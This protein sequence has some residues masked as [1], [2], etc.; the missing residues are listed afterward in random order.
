MNKHYL[1]GLKHSLGFI[2][3]LSIFF[4]II[5]AAGFHSANE[6][7]GGVFQGNFSIIGSMNFTSANT[8]GIIPTGALLSFNSSECPNGWS[9]STSSGGHSIKISNNTGTIIGDMTD[10]GGITASFDGITSQ[11][12]IQSSRKT[13]AANGYIGKDWGAQGAY[14]ITRVDLYPSND[15]GFTDAANIELLAIYTNSA[16]PSNPQ[17][18][19]QIWSIGP[20]IADQTT[21]YS[22]TGISTD[23]RYVW[24]VI[25]GS[26]NSNLYF[27]EIEYYSEGKNCIKN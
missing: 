7:L 3:G 19:V 23:A 21:V 27:A 4:G 13:S 26:T 6:V 10:S 18:G 15:N 12:N 8:Y 20:A 24:G 1:N 14:T 17:D 25:R 5:Y 9:N 11:T 16:A 2:I 22:V